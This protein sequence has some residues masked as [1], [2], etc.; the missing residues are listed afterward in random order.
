MIDEKAKMVL[1]ICDIKHDMIA[2]ML[3]KDTN[4]TINKD[5]IERFINYLNIIVKTNKSKN[6]LDNR[7]LGIYN[8]IKEY[9]KD[10]KKLNAV[11]S[12]N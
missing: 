1:D 2:T 7:I 10:Y 9:Y 3:N 4:G 6:N 12:N 5:D 11:I 8:L